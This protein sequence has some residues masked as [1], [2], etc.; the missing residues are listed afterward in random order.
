MT[1]FLKIFLGT[2]LPSFILFFILLFF[3]GFNS[4]ISFLLSAVLVLAD[5]F[6]IVELSGMVFDSKEP[7]YWKIILFILVKI[8]L[9]TAGLYGILYFFKSEP[10]YIFIGLSL[11]I[12]ISALVGF[13]ERSN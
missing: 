1:F 10:L 4:S 12:A 13:L 11:P 9:L 2:L 6:V 3:K 7:T 8:L 5:I